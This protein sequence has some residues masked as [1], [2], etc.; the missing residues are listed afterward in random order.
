MLCYEVCG[1]AVTP[2]LV[3]IVGAAMVAHSRKT[4]RGRADRVAL[5]RAT[6][7]LLDSMGAAERARFLAATHVAH[8]LLGGAPVPVSELVDAPPPPREGGQAA[9]AA[10]WGRALVVPAAAAVAILVAV[11]RLRAAAR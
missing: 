2:Q 9:P 7:M 8:P 10:A 11:L 1:N 5:R 6:C 3:A 4:Q